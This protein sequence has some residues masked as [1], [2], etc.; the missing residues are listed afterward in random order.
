MHYKLETI[1]VV[2]LCVDIYQ[3]FHQPRVSYVL[4]LQILE[5]FSQPLS[6]LPLHL[7]DRLALTC[8]QS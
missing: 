2:K 6:P 1:P 7:P 3:Q 8:L 5:D 4:S